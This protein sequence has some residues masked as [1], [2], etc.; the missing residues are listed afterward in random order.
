M[1]E[2]LCTAGWVSV[3]GWHKLEGVVVDGFEADYCTKTRDRLM[4][5]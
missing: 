1:Q 5:K 2:K 3:T 4:A